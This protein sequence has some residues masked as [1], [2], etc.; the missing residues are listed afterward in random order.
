MEHATY[1][2]TVLFTQ[3]LCDPTEENRNEV[4]Y[5]IFVARYKWYIA[6]MIIS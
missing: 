6:H 3:E 5:Y 1:T 4:H 2:F